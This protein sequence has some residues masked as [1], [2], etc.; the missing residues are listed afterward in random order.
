M[1]NTI[2][3]L[4]VLMVSLT[5][6]SKD[7]THRLGV[8]FKNNTSQDLPTLAVVYFSSTD[9]ALTGGL[10]VDTKKDYPASQAMV[11]ARYVI[12]PEANLNFYTAG[13]MAFISAENPVDGKKNGVEVAALFG[14]EFF[15]AGLENLGFTMEGGLSLATLNNSRFRTV[16]DSPLRAGLI[17]YF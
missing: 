17:F 6:Y 15:F 16:G 3:A 14:V 11:G 12:Y 4:F 9:F 13:Q 7:L 2:Y 1:K 5:S 10:A 8:G